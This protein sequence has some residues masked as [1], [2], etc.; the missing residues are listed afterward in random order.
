MDDDKK[1]MEK[2]EDCFLSLIQKDLT[3]DNVLYSE[4][5]VM[6][7]CINV[8][9]YYFKQL[10]TKDNPLGSY[11]KKECMFHYKNEK[12]FMNIGYFGDVTTK[13]TNDEQIIDMDYQCANIIKKLFPICKITFKCG[14]VSFTKLF[15][16]INLKHSY[17]SN[18][19]PAYL[20][21]EFINMDTDAIYKLFKSMNV[22]F[23]YLV[24]YCRYCIDKLKGLTEPDTDAYIKIL[25][26][27]HVT[28]IRKKYNCKSI[29]D[30]G[31]L[32]EFKYDENSDIVTLRIFKNNTL[33]IDDNFALMSDICKPLYLIKKFFVYHIYN[34]Y[35]SH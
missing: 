16:N 11:I 35:D 29:E 19:K 6:R 2:I 33:V 18:T 4:N 15:D 32:F 9:P 1:I 30:D 22:E 8:S 14:Y 28:I 23:L 5:D 27:H 10:E 21:S 13:A 25:D 31:C 17:S 34:K 24:N 12:L 20:L 7:C 3:D 26:P